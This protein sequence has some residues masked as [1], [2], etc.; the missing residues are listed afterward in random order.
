MEDH[1]EG[2]IDAETFDLVQAEF[3]RKQGNMTSYSG[4][5]IFSSKIICGEC[6]CCYGSKV[7]HSTDKYRKTVWRC[8]R[9]YKKRRTA[10]V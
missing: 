1:Y 9:K 7:W 10:E 2:I 5:S 6:G 3:K 4:I 8:N